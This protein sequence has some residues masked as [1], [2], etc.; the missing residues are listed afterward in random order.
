[1]ND[2]ANLETQ[3]MTM[4]QEIDEMERL[5][6]QTDNQFYNHHSESLEMES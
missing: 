2:F 4:R 1:M 6:S 5:F 3:N